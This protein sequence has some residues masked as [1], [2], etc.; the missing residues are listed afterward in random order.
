METKTKRKKTGGRKKGTPNKPTPLKECLR[1][2]SA[3]YFE[4]SVKIKDAKAAE[5]LNVKVGTMVSRFDLDMALMEPKDRAT[6]QEKFL[7]YHTP[8]MQSVSA[9]VNVNADIS[10]TIGDRLK[11]LATSNDN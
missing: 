11:S 1:Q 7:R 4:Q 10:A 8:Q 3:A 5:L 9:E 2:V 6:I